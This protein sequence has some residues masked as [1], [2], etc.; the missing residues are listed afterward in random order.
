M[1]TH[2]GHGNSNSRKQG[3][4]VVHAK[5]F[6]ISPLAQA[7]ALAL[8]AGAATVP[9]HAQQRAFSP[10]WFN[11]KGAAQ[12]TATATG[13]LPNGLPASSLAGPLAQQQRANVQLQQSI[14]NLNLAARGIAAQQAAQ[15]AARR[16]AQND[17][18]VPDGLAD[19]GLK[20]DTNSLTAG[21]LNARPLDGESQKKHADGRTV[22]TV[23]QTADRAILNWET[24]NVGRNTTVAFAQQKDWAV[25]N[26]VN[27]PQARPSQIQGRIQADGTV[28]IAN[29]NG[30]VFSGSSQVDTRNLVAAATQI[31]DAQFQAHGV[32]ANGNTPNF[33]NAQGRIEVQAGARLS[34]PAPKSATQGGGYVLLL[35]SEVH[36]AGEIAT[37]GGQAMLAA[38]DSFVI[39]KGVGT[40]GN[41]ASTTRG[42]EVAVTLNANSTA[43]TVRNTGL[44]QAPTGDVTLAGR[45]VVQSGVVLSS[46]SVNAR[47]TVH[48]NAMGATGKVTLGEGSTTAIVLDTSGATALDSQRAGLMAPAVLLD[49]TSGIMLAGNDRRDLSRVEVASGG[50]VE[51]QKDSLTL[52]TGGQVMVDAKQRSLVREGARIDVS[53]AVGVKLTMESNNVK[54]NVQ[55]NEQR[56]A[57]STATARSSTTPSSGSTGARWCWCRAAP[58]ATRAI[59]GTRAAACSRWAATWARGHTV[60]EWMA[61][62][63]AVSFTGGDVVTQRGSSI[64]LS[65]G[66]LDVLT[67]KIN[68]SWLKGADGRLYEVSKAPGDLKYMGVYKGFETST[69]AGAT[70]PPATTTPR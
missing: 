69:C 67:G 40:D 29:R 49:G 47:G 65:G 2:V 3:A 5:S 70:R 53:G 28:M 16:A 6:R 56:D 32:Y 27:D 9:V 37:P 63:G 22:V 46:T 24:F 42:N 14:G 23:E 60:S 31:D 19:G 45:E 55:G 44:I 68:Q 7:M 20:V 64:N 62:G 30:I 61:Q 18:S 39:R 25:L 58:T 52:A 57:P 43:G 50:M 51:F 1:N 48:L 66:T 36:N 13:L 54:I 15:E 34:T 12:A 35:G 17:P 41:Q 38:G 8:A 33:K 11:A 59:A 4:V 26:K 10:T 21:W